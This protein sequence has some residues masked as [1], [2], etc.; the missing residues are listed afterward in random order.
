M[1]LKR[2]KH[3]PAIF[4]EATLQGFELSK[5]CNPICPLLVETQR[6]GKQD[7]EENRLHGAYL[8]PFNDGTPAFANGKSRRQDNFR[9]EFANMKIL[10]LKTA[11][12]R[13]LKRY[14]TG[15]PC[16][17][18]HVAERRTANRVCME[19]RRLYDKSPEGRKWRRLYQQSPKFHF[20]PD[21][22]GKALI[23]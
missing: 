22:K 18:G 19:C 6:D 21:A 8:D 1:L 17:H 10:S 20:L 13:G 12:A 2:G 16:K 11:K 5:A 3:G 4:G 15:K 23:F 7:Q 14:F 9:P